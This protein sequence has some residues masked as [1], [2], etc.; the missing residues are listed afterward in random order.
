MKRN[1]NNCKALQKDF[2]GYG[3]RCVLGYKIE[4]LKEYE[5]ITVSYKPL[6]ECPKPK[7]FSD[8]V[9]FLNCNRFSN[10]K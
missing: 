2:C 8:Y 1:C 3:Y 5:G 4:G 9:S 6:E 7:T 10:A